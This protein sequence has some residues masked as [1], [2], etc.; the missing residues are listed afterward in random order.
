[1]DDQS[2]SSKELC[3]VTDDFEAPDD[4]NFADGLDLMEEFR[5]KGLLIDEKQGR[6]EYWWHPSKEQKAVIRAFF[7][8]RPVCDS[9]KETA[10]A[11][12]KQLNLSYSRVFGIIKTALLRQ[13]AVIQRREYA[14]LLYKEK[15]PIA[16]SIV[17]HSL[18][19][20][21]DYLQNFSP[22]S[23][24]DVKDL[25]GIAKDMTHLLRLELGES[26]EKIE[27]IHKT[28]K[29]VTVLVEEARRNDPFT[30]YAELVESND[31]PTEP[32][33]AGSPSEAVGDPG[34]TPLPPKGS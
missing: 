15:I 24:Q 9:H 32:G 25:V 29:D 22:T 19:K 26:T 6:K 17:G 13:E 3:L 20:V 21:D 27:I 23:I 10:L 31:V 28:Q 4:W 14:D 16:K 2:E 12:S 8:L 30:D 7:E 1:L 11:V 5:Q 34:E 18:Q 33:D